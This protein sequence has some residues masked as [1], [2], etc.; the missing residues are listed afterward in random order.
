MDRDANDPMGLGRFRT[1]VLLGFDAT[2]NLYTQDVFLLDG[3]SS[4]HFAGPEDARAWTWMG[5][6]QW[7]GERLRQRCSW[8]VAADSRSRTTRC[9]YSRDGV[10]WTLQDAGTYRRLD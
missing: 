9:E 6:T 1:L 4:G 7:Q 8:V 10:E 2:R 5:E 3:G